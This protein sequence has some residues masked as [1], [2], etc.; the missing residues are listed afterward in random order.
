MSEHEPM[1][2]SKPCVDEQTTAK[3]DVSKD[4]LYEEMGGKNRHM[5]FP[6][7]DNLMLGGDDT[8]E[9]L[10]EDIKVLP[11]DIQQ[12][13]RNAHS[14]LKVASAHADMGEIILRDEE[15]LVET[16]AAFHIEQTDSYPVRVW[17]MFG[18]LL[19]SIA[20]MLSNHPEKIPFAIAAGASLGSISKG[21]DV[22]GNAY[23]RR[24][25]NRGIAEK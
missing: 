22:L 3:N 24:V 18:G 11:L 21:I 4:M 19:A 6:S 2:R 13:V 8:P 25:Y 7:L 20:P 14:A 17:A 1:D 16:E 15:S 10:E 9:K 12:K 5:H 23:A